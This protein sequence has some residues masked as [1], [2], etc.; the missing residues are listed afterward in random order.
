MPHMWLNAVGQCALSVCVIGVSVRL[1]VP[2]KRGAGGASGDGGGRRGVRSVA[3]CLRLC[4]GWVGTVGSAV[5]IP[6]SIL[7]NLRTPQC[8]YTCITLVC[9][10]LLVRQFKMFLMLLLTLNAHLQHRLG[11]SRYAALVTRQ[12]MLCLVLFS[13]LVSV[14]T[15]FAQF[16]GWNA[17]DSWDGSGAAALGVGRPQGANWSTTFPPYPQDLSVIGRYLPY[18]GFLSKF[19]VTYT[20]NYT[21]AEI[22]GS[23]WGVC[24]ADTVLSP[25][26]M[27]YVYSVTVFILPMLVMLAI[28]LDLMCCG[29]RSSPGPLASPGKGTL[30]HA[31]SVALSI[32]LLALLCLPLHVSHV[33]LLFAP[34]NPQPS[35]ATVLM[36]LLF[37]SY[38]LVPRCCS[39]RRKARKGARLP[40]LWRWPLT[41]QGKSW[42]GLSAPAPLS[43]PP[44]LTQK[45]KCA[46]KH[47]VLPRKMEQCV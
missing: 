37:Q 11:D 43:T 23:H 47:E 46:Q 12:R 19:L 21:Y 14:V 3:G 10:P 7:L 45:P 5:A 13:W 38:G 1:C 32:S 28:Y 36:S 17:Q 25:A 4:L 8:L 39:W 24:A 34:G 9:C 44:A 18:G 15:A 35:W 26:F 20:A 40:H 16:I 29:S 27:V 42:G 6:I 2:R 41:P 30:S 22:H 33:L 31:R